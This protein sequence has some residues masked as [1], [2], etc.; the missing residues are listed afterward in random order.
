MSF[1]ERSSTFSLDFPTI[2]PAVSGEAR[3]KVA[4]HSKGYKGV[5]VWWSFNKLQEVGVFSYLFYFLAKS[6]FYGWGVVEA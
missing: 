2:G 4:L 6:H 1:R 3:G 5:P